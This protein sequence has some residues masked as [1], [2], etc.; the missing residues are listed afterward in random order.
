MPGGA[1]GGERVDVE[2]GPAEAVG[3]AA[4]SGS[5]GAV[6]GRRRGASP[7][8]R[9]AVPAASAS[10][11]GQIGANTAA[12][13]SG[14]WAMSRSNAAASAATVGLDALAPGALGGHRRPRRAGRDRSAAGPPDAGHQERCAGLDREE[15]RPD[16]DRRRGPEERH[17]DAAAG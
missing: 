16:R 12:H 5:L 9:S 4:A 2:V 1:V 8:R 14:A 11:S 13:C 17:L 10:R 15:R 7:W 3:H 6:A